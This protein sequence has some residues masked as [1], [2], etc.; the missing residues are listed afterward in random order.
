MGSASTRNRALIR[1]KTTFLEFER[2]SI[3]DFYS[4][5]NISS[6]T[7]L[8]GK[9]RVSL[10]RYSYIARLIRQVRNAI[11]NTSRIQNVIREHQR[12]SGIKFNEEALELYRN[13]LDQIYRSIK[14]N[15]ARTG[16][17]VWP[18]IL[19]P[20]LLG[21][22]V[23]HRKLSRI[24]SNFPL[25]TRELWTWYGRYVDAQRKFA[26]RHPDLVLIDAA[27]KFEHT[28][29]KERLELFVDLAH[30]TP[31][32]NQKLAGVVLKALSEGGTLK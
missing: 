27:R 28:H 16:L 15:G 2:P 1:K 18:T 23:V 22:P 9:I 24:Y 25:S 5:P 3:Q 11:W 29:G 26:G 7:N 6:E 17:I 30:L 10:Y 13:N 8:W 21:D 20:D 14:I 31:E 12:D 19:A 32:G 4:N